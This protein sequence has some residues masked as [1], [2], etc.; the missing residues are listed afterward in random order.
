MEK[1]ILYFSNAERA[2]RRLQIHE[3]RN[4][5]FVGLCLTVPVRSQKL[6][7]SWH[8]GIVDAVDS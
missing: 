3:W 2:L 4:L 7:R 5:S 8:I 6:F 1:S